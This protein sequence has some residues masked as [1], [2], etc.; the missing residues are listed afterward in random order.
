MNAWT[1][2]Y[3]LDENRMPCRAQMAY[4]PL[5][6]K[7][8]NVMCMNFDTSNMYQ[9]YKNNIG[10]I[11]PIVHN[12]YKMELKYLEKFKNYGWAP[13]V[14]DI[15][16]DKIFIRW[17]DVTCNDVINSGNS[18]DDICPTWKLQ[19]KNAITDQLS[20]RVYKL[21]LYPH[22]HFI[23]LQ[24]QLRAFDCYMSFDFDNY[25]VDLE[26]IN[27]LIHKQTEHRITESVANGNVDMK[28]FF[29]RALES[30]VVWPNNYLNTLY[31]EIKHDLE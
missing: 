11:P 8:Q 4:E 30:H 13:D 28:Q 29:L 12:F 27:G 5:I 9:D 20:E 22:C 10:F 23:D 24:G 26:K 25:F 7:E 21:S 2:Y 15:T 16:Q 14:L 17:N 18:L 6:N 3:K 31:K 1:P 19:L